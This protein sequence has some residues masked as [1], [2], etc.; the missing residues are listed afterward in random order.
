MKSNSELKKKKLR[1]N[2]IKRKSPKSKEHSKSSSQRE[3]HSDTG[4]HKVT[5]KI[6]NKQPKTIKIRR[7]DRTKNQLKR[8]NNI[9]EEI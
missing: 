4:P 7:T 1:K 3:V 9:I 8:G 5:T 6:S 2:T